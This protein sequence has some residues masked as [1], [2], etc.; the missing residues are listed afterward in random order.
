MHLKVETTPRDDSDMIPV[1][2]CDRKMVQANVFRDAVKIVIL[3]VPKYASAEQLL[4]ATLLPL[5]A[6]S[7]DHEGL[8]VQLRYTSK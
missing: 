8:N 6:N 5:D 4:E 7:G 2:H 1:F 3:I